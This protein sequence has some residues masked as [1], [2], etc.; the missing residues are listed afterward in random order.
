MKFLNIYELLNE[1]RR[2][3]VDQ[4]SEKRKKFVKLAESRTQAALNA[5][6]KIGNLSNDRA[7]EFSD[8]DV[9]KILRALKESVGEVEKRF[10]KNSNQQQHFKL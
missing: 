8:E 5:I 3:I 6:R 4:E 10:A 2:N 1:F 9:K 7:Y